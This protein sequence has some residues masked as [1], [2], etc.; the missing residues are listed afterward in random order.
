MNLGA[1]QQDYNSSS[2][3]KTTGENCKNSTGEDNNN[4]DD[5]QGPYSIL[6]QRDFSIFPCSHSEGRRRGGAGEEVGSDRK[7]GN[8][9]SRE[10]QQ[11]HIEQDSY[12]ILRHGDFN[13]GHQQSDGRDQQQH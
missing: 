6:P 3:G 7:I 1:P 8:S 10:L 11:Q 12:A 5:E 2:T 13:C 9:T 4:N